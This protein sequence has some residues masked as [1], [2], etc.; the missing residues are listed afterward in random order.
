M[1]RRKIVITDGV[2][3]AVTRDRAYREN[4]EVWGHKARGY[5]VI[6]WR[7]LEALC[8]QWQY[9]RPTELP[10]YTLH[11]TSP[12][13]RPVSYVITRHLDTGR[14]SEGWYTTDAKSRIGR[15]EVLIIIFER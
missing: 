15:H 5:P 1:A 9:D 12:A 2:T 13:A 3:F 11:A 8:R 4:H 6:T 10:K 14:A 7:T